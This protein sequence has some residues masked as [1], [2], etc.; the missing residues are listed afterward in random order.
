MISYVKNGRKEPLVNKRRVA[1][2]PLFWRGEVPNHF[3]EID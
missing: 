2:K 1:A 3:F